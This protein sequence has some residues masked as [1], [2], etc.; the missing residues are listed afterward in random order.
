MRKHTTNVIISVKNKNIYFQAHLNSPTAILIRQ[1]YIRENI[2]VLILTLK[3]KKFQ[4]LMLC[5]PK[6][7][8][9][10]FLCGIEQAPHFISSKGN[11]LWSIIYVT[12][13]GKCWLYLFYRNTLLF[14]CLRVI[15]SGVYTNAG[16]VLSRV[17]VT[18][19]SV[20]DEEKRV[21]ALTSHQ[22]FLWK[23]D[24]VLPSKQQLK[25]RPVSPAHPWTI[26]F[27]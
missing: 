4:Q 27:H 24:I 1:K 20:S 22:S 16:N 23:I 18:G 19:P 12:H 2:F 5:P 26:R 17:I 7:S 3:Y 14:F 13:P 6:Y 8:M 21:T 15:S 11:M 10:N 9:I 25:N